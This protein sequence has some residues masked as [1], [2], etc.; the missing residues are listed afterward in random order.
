MQDFCTRTFYDNVLQ[1]HFFIS[2]FFMTTSLQQWGNSLA[3]RIPQAVAD[4]MHLTKDT[5][6]R[7]SVE[8]NKLIIEP[9]TP[10]LDELLAGITPE[11]LHTETS[12]EMPR[13]KELW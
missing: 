1:Q 13:G 6:L 12:W 10:S 2:E 7:L 9:D 3:L 8:Q 11:N 4:Q 5:P